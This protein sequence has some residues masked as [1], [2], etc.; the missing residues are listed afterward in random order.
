MRSLLFLLGCQPAAVGDDLRLQRQLR[1]TN[2][3]KP[4]AHREK[5]VK[6]LLRLREAL[7]V[8]R[9]DEEDDCVHLLLQTRHDQS[10][11]QLTAL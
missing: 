3:L 1:R 6:L 7:L 11:L 5:A 8:D 10:K 4:S 9:V 2:D